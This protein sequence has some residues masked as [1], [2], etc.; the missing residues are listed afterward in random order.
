MR[1]YLLFILFF[2]TNNF[3]AQEVEEIFYTYIEIAKAVGDLNNDGLSDSVT[4]IQ[5]TAE[6]EK[7]YILKV[8]FAEPNGNYELYISS[9]KV[10]LPKY[11]PTED[12][13]DA[14]KKFAN[15]YIDKGSLY[16]SHSQ[17]RGYFEHKFHYQNGDFTLVGY[18]EINSDGIGYLTSSYFN[19]ETAELVVRQERLTTGEVINLEKEYK[20]IIP[21]P[22][23][24]DFEP[25]SNE[26]F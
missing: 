15:I 17:L 2:I 7:P 12:E 4:V 14:Q 16:I 18:N 11:R 13:F 3:F 24:Q 1:Y 9:T 21:L 25:L 6:L 8:F 10:V 19:L 23:L 20:R 22:K 26:F 5:D